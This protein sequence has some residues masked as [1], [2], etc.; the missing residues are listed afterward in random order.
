MCTN[1]CDAKLDI[2]DC[3]DSDKDHKCDVCSNTMGTDAT[4]KEPGNESGVNSD[5]NTNEEAGYM[6]IIIASAL[7]VVGIASFAGIMFAKK[8][9]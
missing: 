5:A 4:E 1:G 6:G 9:K 7:G 2:A 3:S 8:K